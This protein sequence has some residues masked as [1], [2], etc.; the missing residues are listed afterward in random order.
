MRLRHNCDRHRVKLVFPGE[1]D[2]SDSGG[3]EGAAAGALEFCKLR[4]P[5]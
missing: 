4:L 1:N 3:P 2:D 5:L